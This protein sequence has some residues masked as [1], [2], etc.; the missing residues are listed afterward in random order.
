MNCG[1]TSTDCGVC[2]GNARAGDLS[3]PFYYNYVHVHLSGLLIGC[4][5]YQ[6]KK[7]TTIGCIKL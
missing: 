1:Y 5:Y 2:T 7:Q 6:N 3:S 4:V